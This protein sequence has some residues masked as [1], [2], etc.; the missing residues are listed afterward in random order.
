[1]LDSE[2]LSRVS[3]LQLRAQK[4]VWGYRFG[5]HRAPRRDSGIEFLEH[6]TYAQGDSLKD[7]DWRVLAR[8]DQ[9]LVRKQQADTDVAAILVV[10]ASGDMN[11]GP[12]PSFKEEGQTK[13]GRALVLA[14]SLAAFLERRGE[15]VGL[16]ILGGSFPQDQGQRWLP[17]KSG[18]RHLA[19]MM[20]ELSKLSAQGEADLAKNLQALAPLAPKRSM[21]F[22]FSDLMEEPDS[23]GPALRALTIQNHQLRVIHHYSKVEWSV[24]DKTAAQFISFEEQLTLPLDM[25]DV[26]EEFLSILEEYR[27][28]TQKWMNKSQALYIPDPIEEPLMNPFFSM[29][30]G[31]HFNGAGR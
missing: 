24:S 13:L 7:I 28:Q 27:A 5:L 3:A 12:P 4:L 14:A 25:R 21:I 31:H 2:L 30:T 15:R 26:H 16:Y 22:L 18:K 19:Q 17:P 6:K 9:L 23:W 20:R 8:R 1:M 10:D 11:V 29:I